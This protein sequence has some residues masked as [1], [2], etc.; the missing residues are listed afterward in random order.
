MATSRVKVEIFCRKCG[1]RYVLRG[2]RDKG[3]LETGFKRCL[4]DN[5]HEL[6]FSVVDY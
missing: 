5:E 1:E 3:R 2:S 6:D 4:C